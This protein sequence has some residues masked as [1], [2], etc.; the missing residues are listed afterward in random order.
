MKFYPRTPGAVRD[1]AL[2]IILAP[3]SRKVRPSSLFSSDFFGLRSSVFDRQPRRVVALQLRIL[4]LGDGALC[5]GAGD[6]HGGAR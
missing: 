5:A 4:C 1:I 2:W 6:R 3:V